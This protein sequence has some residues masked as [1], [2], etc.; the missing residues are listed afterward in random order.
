M[1]L[2]QDS[3]QVNKKVIKPTGITWTQLTFT[4]LHVKALVLS[5]SLLLCFLFLWW[6]KKKKKQPT[7][8]S[9]TWEGNALLM[10]PENSPTLKEVREQKLNQEPG[11][12]NWSREHG[13]KLLASLISLAC[14]TY[15][16]FSL[17]GF[18][19]SGC[20]GTHSIKQ[21]G[22]ELRDPPAS[23]SQMLGLKGCATTAQLC[24]AF[25]I[26][27]R[28]ISPGVALCIVGWASHINH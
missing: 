25:L 9:P 22:L 20:P 15:F 24:P 23:A 1:C 28:T 6:F 18:C 8:Q 19:S 5:T 10:A 7:G 17:F 13:G 11:S 2:M 3:L 12:R 26:Q 4:E 16:L 14:S 27:V 21:A